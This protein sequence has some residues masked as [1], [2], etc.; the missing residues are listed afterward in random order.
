MVDDTVTMCVSHVDK[1]T[2]W[3]E[4]RPHLSY[5]ELNLKTTTLEN[6]LSL[7]ELHSNA[8]KPQK[9][10]SKAGEDAIS[11]KHKGSAIRCSSQ[12]APEEVKRSRSRVFLQE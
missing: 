11:S 4:S 3:G 6:Q 7:V 1:E 12:P 2:V 5:A 10:G 9:R 8:C